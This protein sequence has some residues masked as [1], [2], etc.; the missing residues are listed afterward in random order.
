[1]VEFPFSENSVKIRMLV[2]TGLLHHHCLKAAS[3]NRTA[4]QPLV[5][6]PSVFRHVDDV[7]AAGAAPIGHVPPVVQQRLL[8]RREFRLQNPERPAREN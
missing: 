3:A 4:R 5:L 2:E 7:V 8:K 1:M 6:L